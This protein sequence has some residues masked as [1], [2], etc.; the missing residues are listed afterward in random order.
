MFMV[1][2]WMLW[3]IGARV[4]L[5]EQAPTVAIQ[6]D[7]TVLADFSADA[8][9]RLQVGQS[10]QVH[11]DQGD[12]ATVSIPAIVMSL[13][14]LP[15]CEGIRAELQALGDIFPDNPLQAGQQGRVEIVAERISPAGLVLRVSGQFLQSDLLAARSATPIDL[16][17]DNPL[18]PR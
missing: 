18:R 3:F 4:T 14:D 10:A 16:E 8:A 9:A 11:L 15:A 1:G 17:R 6:A 5:L 12:G 2:L 7:G 13:T